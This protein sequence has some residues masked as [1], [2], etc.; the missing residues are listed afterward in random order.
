MPYRGCTLIPLWL[1]CRLVS[2]LVVNEGCQALG[3]VPPKRMIFSE[4]IT[5]RLPRLCFKMTQ[6][7]HAISILPYPPFFPFASLNNGANQVSLSGA[8]HPPAPPTL[9]APL[10]FVAP[11]LCLLSTLACPI[12]SCHAAASRPPAPPPIISPPP[13]IVPLLHLLSS[14]LL[15]HLLSH[16][17]LLSACTSASHHTT[18]SHC[19]PLMLFVHQPMWLSGRLTL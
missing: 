10:P 7:F 8:S 5:T 6:I 4:N 15:H 11:L 16:R 2:W 18:K 14:W 13:F 3:D 9:V 1:V 19:A 12:T 17:R